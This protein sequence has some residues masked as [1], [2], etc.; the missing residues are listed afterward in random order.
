MLVEAGYDVDFVG[1]GNRPAVGDLPDE[2]DAD[3]EGHGGFTIGP[4]DYVI[5]DQGDPG[6]IDA[7]LDEWLAD[8]PDVILLLIGVNDMFDDDR[9]VDPAE[10]DD[11]L[12][13]IVERIAGL[14]PDARL[15]VSSYPPVS[16]FMDFDNPATREGAEAFT[17]LQDAIRAAGETRDDDGIHYVPTIETLTDTWTEG[18]T[19]DGLH[20]A[21]EGAEKLARVWFDALAPILDQM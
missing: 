21:P 11:K 18:D 8:P 13:A 3:H 7:Y 5:N 1:S 17:D 15:L 12:T 19:V 4:D 9:P 20:P 2:P 10:A 6:N 16:Y 14:A